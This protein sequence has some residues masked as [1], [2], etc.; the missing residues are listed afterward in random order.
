MSCFHLPTSI[1]KKLNS[2]L[3]RF[4]VEWSKPLPPYSLAKMDQ[5]MS[6][7]NGRR[8]RVSFF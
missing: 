4:L 6:K 2:H 5:F 1:C 8:T 3:A 7:K